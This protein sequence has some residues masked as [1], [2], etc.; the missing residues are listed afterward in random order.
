M[1]K[2]LLFILLSSFLT[3]VWAGNI[4]ITKEPTIDL[5][6][7]GYDNVTT[8]EMSISWENSWRDEHNWDAVHV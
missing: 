2:L 7:L 3:T 5:L 6:S 8:I 1:K 4:E